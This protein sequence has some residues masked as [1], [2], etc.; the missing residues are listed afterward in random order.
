MTTPNDPPNPCIPHSQPKSMTP[1]RSP[2]S[3]TT[4]IWTSNMIPLQLNL[5]PITRFANQYVNHI[6][7]M[8]RHC[9]RRYFSRTP[10]T[11]CPKRPT[12]WNNPLYPIRSFFLHWLFLSILPLKP[13]PHPRT[14]RVLTT[15]RHPPTKPPRSATPKYIRVA[16]LRSVN[17]LS[18]P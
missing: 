3:P 7:M 5:P 12:I 1:H 18:S 15:H 14:R 4:N 6:P 11:H 2:I 9:T 16:G 17:Y 13:R 10:H 8:T